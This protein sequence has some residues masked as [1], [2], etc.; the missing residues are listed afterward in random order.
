[1][2]IHKTLEELGAVKVLEKYGIEV[3]RVLD[4]YGSFFYAVLYNGEVYGVGKNRLQALRFAAERFNGD[5]NPFRQLY[6]EIKGENEEG[7]KVHDQLA[8]LAV[9]K[10]QLMRLAIRRGCRVLLGRWGAKDVAYVDGQ[11]YVT[12]TY[13]DGSVERMQAKTFLKESLKIICSGG[14]D[15]PA[16]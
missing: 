9:L 6:H 14:G 13:T 1:M 4:G 7:R 3:Y 8:E 5:D 10:I 2:T 11:G 15:E 12:V 16:S